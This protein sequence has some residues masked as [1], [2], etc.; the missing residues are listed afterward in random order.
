MNKPLV[1]VIIPAFN[2]SD[3]IVDAIDS[4]LQQTYRPIEVIVVDDGSTDDTREKLKSLIEDGKI[5]YQS[6]ANR[7]LAAARNTG[8]KLAKGTYLQFLDADDLISPTK[9]E[10][11]VRCLETSPAPAICGCDFRFFEGKNVSKLYGG[12]LYKGQFP[13]NSVAHLFEFETVIHRW[14]FS[15]SLFDVVGNFEEDMPATEDWLMIW[16]LAAS[17]TRFLYLDEPMALYRKHDKN[18]T[19]DFKRAAAGHLRALD[20]VERYQKQQGSSLYSKR[21]LNALREAYH[22]ELGLFYMRT[23]RLPRA[24]NHLLKALTLSS[25][26]RQ[27]K[28]LLMVALPALGSHALQWVKSADNRLWRWRAQLRKIFAG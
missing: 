14:L 9:I 18:M 22:Y 12:D 26:R 11:Q 25:N 7:G 23:K 6:Q 21:E 27:I 17:G 19:C 10:K 20:H 4:A 15:A 8:I 13:L 28:L 1:S 16:K 3:Y 5:R 24:W 2:S